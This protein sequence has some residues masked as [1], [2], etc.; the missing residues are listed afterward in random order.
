MN[1]NLALVLATV[2]GGLLA[3]AA[4]ARAVIKLELTV[5]KMFQTSKCVLTGA[6]DKLDT[7]R[8]VVDINITDT[9]KGQS[10]GQR[11]RLQI[12]SPADL[13]Q[14]IQPGQ[15][16]V[17][18]LGGA[19]STSIAAVHLADTWLL[20]NEIPGSQQQAWQVMKT[21]DD[22][23]SSF[24][25]RTAA[26]AKLVMELKAG[27]S[28]ILD[29][30]D[31]RFFRGGVR[32]LGQLD[33][34]RPAWILPADFSGDGRPDLLVGTSAG[35]RLF[36]ATANG[37]DDVT[38]QW[39]AWGAVGG[40]HAA[41]DVNGD[42]RVDLLL[43]DTLWL[44]TGHK[45]AAAK[46]RL[47]LPAGHALAAALID[48]TGDKRPD[49]VLVM[50]NGQCQVLENPGDGDQPWRARPATSL[51]KESPPA[52]AYVGD[53]GD[54]GQP[55]VLAVWPDRIV[56][57]ALDES[58]SPPASIE[59]LTGVELRKHR[60]YGAGLARLRAVPMDL[61]GDGRRD[62]FVVC[63]AGQFALVNRGL[64]TFLFDDDTG[65]PF[66]PSESA[67]LPF[68]FTATT[69]WAAASAVGG[70]DDLLVLAD[71]GSVHLLVGK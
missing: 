22:A 30:V 66:T 36:M 11:V 15:S 55:H 62:L 27:R 57:Y 26:L 60:R 19:R 58:D 68:R 39:A 17:L 38:Q 14:Q 49:A 23:R 67:R 6:V 45:F 42:G 40:Y 56:R 10:P 35:P 28:P 2:V 70:A 53:W 69:L 32:K 33:V 52:A 9:A 24:P 21:H 13:I 31:Q 1:R 59:R 61:N 63:D 12:V 65:A 71:D 4:P 64:G 50:T 51:W 8:R 41:G 25:G 3:W 29:R 54:S 37:F 43:D 5:A 47:V 16:A 7:A 34:S 18:F 46:T 44:N 48:V 20:A